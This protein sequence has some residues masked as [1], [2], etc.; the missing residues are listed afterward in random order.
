MKHRSADAALG[1]RLLSI[2]QHLLERQGRSDWWPGETAFEVC[3]GAILTQNT[4][5]SNVERALGVLR[6]QRLL[7]FAR[8]SSRSEDELAS[9]IRSAG[10]HRVKARRVMAFLAFLGREYGGRVE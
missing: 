5:W 3:L 6:N 2:Y 8:L 9:L 7:S 4:S 1:H 10:C